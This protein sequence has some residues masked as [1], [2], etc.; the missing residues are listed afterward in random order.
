MQKEKQQI[1]KLISEFFEK[2][3]TFEPSI[4]HHSYLLDLG[5][6]LP[7]K[8]SVIFHELSDRGTSSL[9]ENNDEFTQ[10]LENLKLKYH[11]FTSIV[12]TEDYYFEKLTYK[13]LLD[14]R[15]TTLEFFFFFAIADI[16]SKGKTLLCGT[17]SEILFYLAPLLEISAEVY[18]NYY[19]LSDL[20]FSARIFHH[21][22]KQVIENDSK[23]TNF[24]SIVI[25]FLIAVEEMDYLPNNFSKIIE[26]FSLNNMHFANYAL[27]LHVKGFNSIEYEKAFVKFY[28][29]LKNLKETEEKEETCKTMSED[30]KTVLQYCDSYSI[31]DITQIYLN[32]IKRAKTYVFKNELQIITALSQDPEKQKEKFNEVQEKIT[33]IPESLKNISP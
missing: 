12:Q 29:S 31:L 24:F 20:K 7:E 22:L 8:L 9:F 5:Q 25:N 33:S 11:F 21:S 27:W 14:I 6:Q 3:K 10:V 30:L 15:N 32:P 18:S 4:P 16:L 13:Q 1:S 23:I 17:A 19:S 28:K 26:F 2:L